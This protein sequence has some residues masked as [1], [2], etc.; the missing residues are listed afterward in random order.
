MKY[1]ADELIL[2]WSWKS[3]SEQLIQMTIQALG[4]QCNRSILKYWAYLD[5]PLSISF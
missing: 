1:V 5:I 3:L 2:D 4:S